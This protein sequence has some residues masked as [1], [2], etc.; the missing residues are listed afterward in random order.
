MPLLATL[1]TN[2]IV[3]R[4]EALDS[5]DVALAEASA[6]VT[7]PPLGA[8]WLRHDGTSTSAPTTRT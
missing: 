3:F 1:G 8:V 7:V 2:Q 6:R 5:N 4:A